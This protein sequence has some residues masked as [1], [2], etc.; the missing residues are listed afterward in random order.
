MTKGQAVVSQRLSYAI[1]EAGDKDKQAHRPHWIAPDQAAKAE[2]QADRANLAMSAGT[3][4][5]VSRIYFPA[6][7][8]AGL[9][10]RHANG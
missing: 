1:W 3:E 5:P 2:R 9:M 7:C 6:V 4:I 10:P 8:E